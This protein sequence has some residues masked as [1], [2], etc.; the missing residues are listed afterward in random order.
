MFKIFNLLTLEEKKKLSL[1]IFLVIVTSLF[2][3]LFFTFIQPILGYFTGS[4]SRFLLNNIN[5]SS[6]KFDFLIFIFLI[7][8][9]L[10]SLF[11][12]LASYFK[13]IFV[14]TLNDRISVSIFSNYVNKDYIF[15]TQ[16]NT[17][18]LISNIIIEVEKFSYRVIDAFLAFLTEAFLVTSIII[19]LFLNYFNYTFFITLIIFFLFGL[20]FIFYKNKFYNM[21]SEKIF[22]DQKKINDLQKSFYVIQNIKLDNLED[23]FIDRFRI[24]TQQS[25]KRQFL[26]QFIL[27]LPKPLIETIIIVLLVL[28][29]ITSIYV[30][31]S[32]PNEII[33]VLGIFIVALFRILPS[34]NRIFNCTNSFRFYM[35]CVDIIYK[36]LSHINNSNKSNNLFDPQK[37]DIIFKDSIILKN[38]LYY[39]PNTKNLILDNISMTIKK[40][41]VIGIIGKS[42]SGK[43]TLLNI[44][45]GLIKPQGGEILVDGKSVDELNKLFSKRIGYVTQRTYLTDESII[46]NIIFG[47]KEEYYDKDLFNNIIKK[48]KLDSLINKLPNRENTLVGE[49]GIAISGGEQQRIGI[50]RALYKKP[51]ILILDESTSALDRETEKEILKIISNF[52]NEITVIIVSHKDELIEQCQKVFRVD[53][54]KVSII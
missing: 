38:I 13:N 15:F 34:C 1:I 28:F 12:I 17:S 18:E 37:G 44:L 23:F 53:N 40:N 39:Y 10:R 19:F 2:E 21:G 31:K 26:L 35:P 4:E 48:V 45:C 22:Y 36:E 32:A 42:G 14:K 52:R 33:A 29:L 24:N 43:T 50:A 27:E 47:I 5:L 9:F 11:Y 6:L 54:N 3:I 7:I 49:M 20:I 25:S 16:N 30:F 46:K 51:E 8:F 41:E